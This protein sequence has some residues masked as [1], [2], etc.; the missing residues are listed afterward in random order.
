MP[1]LTVNL[2]DE[3]FRFSSEQEWINKAQSWFARCEVPKRHYIAIDAAGRVCI[4]GAEFMR[5]TRED[6]YPITVYR[7][8]V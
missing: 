6:T 2:G 3:M 1:K 5:A 4:K 8:L 7:L